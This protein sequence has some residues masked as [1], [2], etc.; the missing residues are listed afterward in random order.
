MCLLTSTVSQSGG[1]PLTRLVING[2][3]RLNVSTK[4][5]MRFLRACTGQFES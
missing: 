1:L 3:C 5:D 2:A 4:I